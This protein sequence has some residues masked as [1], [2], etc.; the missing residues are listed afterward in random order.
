MISHSYCVPHITPAHMTKL[1]AGTLIYT[2]VLSPQRTTAALLVD[3]EL[4]TGYSGAGNLA[5][6]LTS[7]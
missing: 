7:T 1:A 5:R 4:G 6:S 3:N 2:A